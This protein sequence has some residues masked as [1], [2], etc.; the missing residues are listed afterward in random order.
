MLRIGFAHSHMDGSRSVDFGTRVLEKIL[1][2]K[3][4]LALVIVASQ[5]DN[6]RH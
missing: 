3:A 6:R 5:E 1:R 4:I 2:R